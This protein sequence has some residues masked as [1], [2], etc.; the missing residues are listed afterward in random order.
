[1]TAEAGD[2]LVYIDP[3]AGFEIRPISPSERDFVAAVIAGSSEPEREAVMATALADLPDAQVLGGF[4][5]G[6]MVAAAGLRRDG[7][8]NDVAFLVVVPGERR[9]GIGRAMLHDALRRSGRRPLAAQIPEDTLPF[10]KACGFKLVGRRVQ[11]NGDIH[12][13]VGWH[14][15]GA[16]FKGG[17]SD[18]LTTQSIDGTSTS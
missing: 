3:A 6:V 17:T 11:P 14:T 18:A 12:F 10:F 8:A 9:R 15:P 4:R 5:D 7:L 1:M 16:R 2:G 13:R